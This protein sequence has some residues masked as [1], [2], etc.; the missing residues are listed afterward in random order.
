VKIR[1]EEERR[2]SAAHSLNE[3]SFESSLE[4]VLVDSQRAQVSSII[5]MVAEVDKEVLIGQRAPM[6]WLSARNLAS[7]VAHSDLG[8][9]TRPSAV[10]V[11][12]YVQILNS[13]K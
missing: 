13:E 7:R 1:R 2:G 6:K 10:N 12:R 3:S 4:A 8:D 9:A 5:S 11:N